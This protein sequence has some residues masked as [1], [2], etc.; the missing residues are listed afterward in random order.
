MKTDLH[1]YSFYEEDTFELNLIS[2]SYAYS[3]FIDKEL[4]RKFTTVKGYPALDCKYRNKDGSFSKARYIMRGPSYYALIAKYNN[5]NADLHNFPESFRITPYRY[6]TSKEITD[7]ALH[8]QVVVPSFNNDKQEE[9]ES[10]IKLQELMRL[11]YRGEEDEEASPY[12]SQVKTRVFG[13]DTTGEKIF[14]FYQP[15]S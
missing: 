13:N 6:P 8:F 4:T 11:I 14:V 7:T 9:D 2:E 5:E 1:N 15:L 12:G 3:P 10:R